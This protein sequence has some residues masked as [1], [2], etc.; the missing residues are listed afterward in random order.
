MGTNYYAVIKAKNELRD[1]LIELIANGDTAD[2]DTIVNMANELYGESVFNY[3][4]KCLIGAKIHLG[5]KSYGW[6]FLWEHHLYTVDN[7]HVEETEV[8][9]GHTIIKYVEE[10]K[11]LYSLYGDL[12]KDNI[13]SFLMRD[14]VDI[15]NEYGEL[16]NKEEFIEWSFNTEGVDSLTCG[17][18]REQ[19][20]LADEWR[21]PIIMGGYQ[22]EP[23]AT[24]FYS[25]GL[26]FA[27]FRDF[28]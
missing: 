2:Y 21:E 5:R 20:P 23:G 14:N 17:K 9:P 6:K 11:T 16:Q 22:I 19:K 25:D 4:E 1:K 13:R 27:A 15:Y 3:G 12:T 24:D 26:R 28:R 10:P 7:G 18:L 8:E